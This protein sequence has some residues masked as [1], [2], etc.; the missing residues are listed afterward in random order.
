MKGLEQ[1]IKQLQTKAAE[2]AKKLADPSKLTGKQIAKLGKEQADFSLVLE[3]I[4]QW[5]KT[6]KE[7]KDN[8][9]MI[10]NEP[11]LAEMAKQENIEL[12]KQEKKLKNDLISQLITADPQ[13]KRDVI[14][15]I[16]SGT[17]GE[18]AELFAQVLYRIYQRYAQEQGWQFGISDLKRS[19]LGGIKSAIIEIKGTNVFKALKYEGGVHRVQRVPKTEKSGR[20]HTSAATVAVLPEADEKEIKLDNQDLDIATFRSSGPGG[21]SVNT[22]DSAVRVTHKPTGV[23]VS[24]QDEKSQ[25]KNRAKAITILKARLLAKQIEDKQAKQGEKRKIMIGSG[26][27]SEKIRTYNF[28]QNRVTDHRINYS[29]H[30][31]EGV[32]QGQLDELISKLQQADQKAKLEEIK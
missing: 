30:N 11:E 25:L 29:S 6:T 22:T 5:Q 2:L 14:I 18:E 12:V 27:R 24:C 31:L 19:D 23:S 1:K 17:G 4:D 20:I 26:D 16:R 28:P 3:K 32:L 15:E 10:A 13:D 21:Q 9:Q 8:K 7:V